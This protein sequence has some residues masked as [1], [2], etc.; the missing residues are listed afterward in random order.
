MT[1][2][3]R[4]MRTSRADE[5][6]GVGG[7]SA[8]LIPHAHRRGVTEVGQAHRL[9]GLAEGAL[10]L[11]PRPRGALADDL[12]DEAVAGGEGGSPPPPPGRGGGVGGGGGPPLPPPAAS[13]PPPVAALQVFD[14]LLI[15]VKR[16]VVD[17]HGVALDVAGVGGVDP[18][19]VRVHRHHL[20]LHRL[21]VVAE[22]DGVAERFSHLFLS[23][24][25]RAP[26]HV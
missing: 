8:I 13:L 21:A 10:A 7:F 24:Y 6:A 19:R 26:W 12:V 9:A 18:R 1:Q 20:P 2:L 5:A 14:L 3:M 16:V 17:E 22:E 11:L 23:L 25:S 4:L 15:V